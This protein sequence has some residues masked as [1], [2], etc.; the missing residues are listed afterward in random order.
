MAAYCV[1]IAEER[2]KSDIF[3]Q[4]IKM[5]RVLARHTINYLLSCRPVPPNL[6]HGHLYKN[7][8]KR[9]ASMKGKVQ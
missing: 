6:R 1:R 7:L 2:F 5:Q 9:I 4:K 3:N 8:K